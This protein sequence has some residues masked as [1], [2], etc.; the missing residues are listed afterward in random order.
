M[1]TCKQP[2]VN[3]QIGVGDSKYVIANDPLLTGHVT[4][5]M[6]RHRVGF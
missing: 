6:R 4:W 5:R 3:T 1:F 2:L